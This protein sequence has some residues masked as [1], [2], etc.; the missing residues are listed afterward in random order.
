MLRR[1]ILRAIFFPAEKVGPKYE[2]TVVTTRDKKTIRGLVVSETAQALVLK[3]AEDAQPVTVQ[4]AQILIRAKPQKA[5]IMPED[6]IDK[7]GGDIN[8]ANVVAFLMAGK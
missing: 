6:L 1:D 5:T 2:T 7:A 4:K 3:T 8:I